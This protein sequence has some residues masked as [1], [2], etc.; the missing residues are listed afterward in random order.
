MATSEESASAGRIDSVGQT[1]TKV[2]EVLSR[3]RAMTNAT[4]DIVCARFD[5]LSFRPYDDNFRPPTAFVSFT[6]L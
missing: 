3:R 1:F 5:T 2:S 4:Q 6:Y